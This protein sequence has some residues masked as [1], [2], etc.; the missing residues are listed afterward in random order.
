MEKQDIL[1]KTW[2]DLQHMMLS[3]I[4]QREKDKY[5]T[6]PLTCG[7]QKS[8]IHKKQ[9]WLPGEGG[10]RIKLM[11]KGTNLTQ[12]INTIIYLYTKISVAK[13]VNIYV[14]TFV[15]IRV[16]TYTHIY[17]D[18]HTNSSFYRSVFCLTV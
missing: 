13:N 5:S 10:V 7:I 9:R 11:F 8:Q 15:H 18:I 2:V 4:S 1:P 6:I 14:Y 17:S 12:I 16:H 3:E